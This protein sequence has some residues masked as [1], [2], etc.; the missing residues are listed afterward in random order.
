MSRVRRA[1]T[2]RDC[3]RR[4]GRS[5]WVGKEHSKFSQ[6]VACIWKCYRLDFTHN[7]VPTSHPVWRLRSEMIRKARR[8]LRTLCP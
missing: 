6:S 4:I 5:G 2:E 7:R 1:E 8:Q 3:F